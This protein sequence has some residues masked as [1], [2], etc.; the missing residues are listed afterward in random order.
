MNA[1]LLEVEYDEDSFQKF[2]EFNDHNTFKVDGDA[3]TKKKGEYQLQSVKVNKK[4]FL[5]HIIDGI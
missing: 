3:V 2:F 1:V 4:A 5:E